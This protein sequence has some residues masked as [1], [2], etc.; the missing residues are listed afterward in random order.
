MKRTTRR[1]LLLV[2]LNLLVVGALVGL[3]V[4]I[5]L[6]WDTIGPN[7]WN[8]EKGDNWGDLIGT[9]AVNTIKYTAIAFFGGLVLAVALALGRLSPVFTLRWVATAYIEFFRGLPALLVIS[10]MAFGPEIA[11]GWTPPGGLIGAGLL[12][13]ILVAGAY[14][15]ETVR[16]GIQAVPKGQTEAARSLGMSGGATMFRV[17]LP[18][19]FRIV[20][21]PLTNEFVLLIKDTALLAIIGVEFGQ[22]ELTTVA[23]DFESSGATA[24]TAT[25]L[26]QAALI[27]LVITIPLTQFVSWLERRQRRASR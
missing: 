20:I 17:V 15:A 5:T 4:A 13:L 9:G 25:S 19:A 27:Y 26:I 21:P 11:F 12:A 22:R 6:N 24:G 14:M 10:F 2:L 7:F 8:P 23:R 1:L 3:V 18:Q 16:A